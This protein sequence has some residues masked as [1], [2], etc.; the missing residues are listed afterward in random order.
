MLSGA[1]LHLDT[2]PHLGLLGLAYL[3]ARPIGKYLGSYLAAHKYGASI[4]IRQ[5]LGLALLPQA[6][7][8]IGMVITVSET[9]PD[10][11]RTIG[12]VILS[13]VIVYEAVGPFLTRLALARAKEIHL[14]E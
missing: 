5:N 13:S 7:V 9:H 11:G 8:A 12:T 1:S 4:A 6:G 3:I 2:L 14:V 10:L